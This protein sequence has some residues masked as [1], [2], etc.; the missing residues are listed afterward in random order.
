MKISK[1][2][3]YKNLLSA[4]DISPT[5]GLVDYEFN[6]IIE[7]LDSTD[8]FIDDFNNE[9]TE[10]YKN[11]SNSFDNFENKIK[12]I[13][14]LLSLLIEDKIK[15]TNVYLKEY[16][17]KTINEL[18]TYSTTSLISDRSKFNNLIMKHV[19]WKYPAMII[20]PGHEDYIQDMIGFDPL[21]LIDV[22]KEFLITGKQRFN[23][24]YQRRLREYIIGDR[25][26][27]SN[28][29]KELPDNQ[30]GFCFV[31]NFFNKRPTELIVKYLEEIYTKLRPG[32][33]IGLTFNNCEIASGVE[34]VELGKSCYTLDSVITQKAKD[35]GY[36]IIYT[37]HFDPEPGTWLEL[38]KPGEL[39]SIKAGQ[40]LAKIVPK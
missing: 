28:I 34:L 39:T 2:V 17:M 23:E 26:Q 27:T 37:E 21:Y 40:I 4:I 15:D 11:I 32:G 16:D 5:K 22:N 36:E 35:I 13:K 33:V 18:V 6:K 25:D 30:F 10:Q 38:K 31:Y 14:N 29:L 1:L 9:I 24:L 7:D 19:S 12:Q 20:R 8:L 3:A